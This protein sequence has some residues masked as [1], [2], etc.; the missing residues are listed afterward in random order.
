MSGTKTKTSTLTKLTASIAILGISLALFVAFPSLALG[1]LLDIDIPQVGSDDVQPTEYSADTMADQVSGEP[2]RYSFASVQGASSLQV[3]HGGEVK[4]TIRFYNIDGNRTTHIMLEI[5]QAP[6]SWDVQ[7]DPPLSDTEIDF[8]GQT[9][10]VAEN[11]HVEPTQ[12]SSEEIENVPEGTVLFSVPSRGY[13]LA[14]EATITIRVPQSE[15]VG[16][17][18]HVKITAVASWPG[19]HGEARICQTRDF[20]FSVKIL[21]TNE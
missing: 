10:T 12:L 9:I 7:I 11:L 16:T 3:I 4:A 14:K 17:T 18:G 1:S 15:Q 5:A 20:D 19:Q 13:T 2:A 6:D 8:G 21:A